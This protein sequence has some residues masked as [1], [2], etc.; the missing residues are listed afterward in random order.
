MPLP[1]DFGTAILINVAK[2]I[3]IM[4]LLPSN[5]TRLCNSANP[6]QGIN[7]K[8]TNQCRYSDD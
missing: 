1:V 4:R 7:C 6:N 3:R 2:S 8:N 5:L